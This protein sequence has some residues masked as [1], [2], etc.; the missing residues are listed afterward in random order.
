MKSSPTR[1][2]TERT[3]TMNPPSPSGKTMLPYRIMEAVGQNCAVAQSATQ[4]FPLV[5]RARS[6]QQVTTGKATIVEQ[7]MRALEDAVRQM[8]SMI[9][10]RLKTTQPDG[11]DEAIDDIFEDGELR[12][13]HEMLARLTSDSEFRALEKAPLTYTFL[14]DTIGRENEDRLRLAIKLEAATALAASQ[15]LTMPRQACEPAVRW[16][17]DIYGILSEPS[18]PIEAKSAILSSRRAEAAMLGLFAL[19]GIPSAQPWLPLALLDCWIGSRKTMLGFFASMPNI[20]VDAELDSYIERI[21]LAK[22]RRDHAAEE[23]HFQ[24]CLEE[25]RETGLPVWLNRS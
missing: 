11:L 15:I 20:H 3:T 17:S 16:P 10:D 8:L 18:I 13:V 22:M 25:A 1:Y 2:D 21:D 4:I 23:K 12:R 14:F 5:A 6:P 24:V 7:L 9:A 19:P